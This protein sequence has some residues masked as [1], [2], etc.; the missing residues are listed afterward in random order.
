[1]KK[2]EYRTSWCDKEN[3]ECA[4]VV[5]VVESCKETKSR[6]TGTL[7]INKHPHTHHP[8]NAPTFGYQI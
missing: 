5:V 4:V 3:A 1:M 8:S 6:L 7:D 2:Y